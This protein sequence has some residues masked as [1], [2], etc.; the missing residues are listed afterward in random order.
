MRAACG[1]NLEREMPDGRNQRSRNQRRAIDLED[2]SER[3]TAEVYATE[4]EG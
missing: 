2:A 4:L 1:L 3:G